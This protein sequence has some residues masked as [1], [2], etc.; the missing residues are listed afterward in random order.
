MNYNKYYKEMTTIADEIQAGTYKRPD[1]TEIRES[2]IKKKDTSSDNVQEDIPGII[3]AKYMAS[4][5]KQAENEIKI[6][7]QIQQQVETQKVEG[8]VEPIKDKGV[9]VEMARAA[10]NKYSIPE[11]LF[12]RLVKQESGFQPTAKSSAGAY[13]LAQLM[14]DTAEY[15]GVDIN[16]PK[17]NIEGGAR[18][19]K[20]QYDKYK[21]WR[22]AL[23]AYNAGP[24]NV[25]K[26]GGVPPFE[27]T[28]NYVRIILGE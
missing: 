1:Y 9:Y 19:L 22:L 7:E 20:E 5:R 14:P 15:L 16:K 8:R 25:D 11:N 26:Y 27:E 4:V 17:Q 18:Y 2:F 24:G 10:A 28:Q 12:L 3:M 21:N 6:N 23:A 13:G